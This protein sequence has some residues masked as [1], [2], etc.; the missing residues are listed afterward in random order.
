MD[1]KCNRQTDSITMPILCVLSTIVHH[2]VKS[3]GQ[4]GNI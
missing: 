1:H 2:M 3:V 4:Q